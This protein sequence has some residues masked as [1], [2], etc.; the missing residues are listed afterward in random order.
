M[1]SD[2]VSGLVVVTAVVAAVSGAIGSSV[3]SRK[4]A[5]VEGFWLGFLLGPLG[6]LIVAIAIDNRPQCHL[7]HGRLDGNRDRKAVEH[8]LGAPVRLVSS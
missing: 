2:F 1:T 5:G 6:I 4:N 8:V 3:G 7:C